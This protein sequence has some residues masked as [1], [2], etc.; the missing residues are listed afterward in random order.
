MKTLSTRTAA[1]RMAVL[2]ASVCALDAAVVLCTKQPLVG[3]RW[4]PALI[5]LLTPLTVWEVF[6][7]SEKITK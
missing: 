3:A 4:I 7:T 6:R 2:I 5:P 1:I